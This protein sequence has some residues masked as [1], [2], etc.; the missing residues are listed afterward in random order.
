MCGLQDPRLPTRSQ[1]EAVLVLSLGDDTIQ[2][3]SA[4]L[5][6]RAHTQEPALVS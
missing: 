5:G 1:T 4:R 6:G 3:I 2:V